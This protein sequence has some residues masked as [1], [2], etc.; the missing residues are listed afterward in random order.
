METVVVMVVVIPIMMMQR[1]ALVSKA[2][3]MQIAVTMVGVAIKRDVAVQS[4]AWM[5]MVSSV[6]GSSLDD[7]L[8]EDTTKDAHFIFY[9]IG[10]YV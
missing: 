6:H 4:M 2:A 1:W 9:A 10:L 5:I 3:W 7:R 8:R